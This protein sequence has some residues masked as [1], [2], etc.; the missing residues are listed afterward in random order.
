M[1]EV[2]WE[3]MFPDELEA[4]MAA[5]PVVWV[6]QG[7]CE[8]HGPQNALGLDALKA[9]AICVAAAREHGGIVA[10]VDFWHIH[11]TGLYA[12]WAFNAIG[13]MRTWMTA[14]PAWIHF[15]HVC[16]QWRAFDALG[17]HAAITVTGHYGANWT[18][19]K[20]LTGLVQ[21]HLAMRL[22]GLPDWEANINGFDGQGNNKGDHAG[23]VETSLLWALRPECV[24]VSRIPP[25]DV[26]KSLREER[27]HF[28]MGADAPL[29]D[30]RVGE[31]MVRD[32][33]AYLGRRAKELLAAYDRE[34]PKEHKP[35]SFVELERIWQ[36]VVKPKLPTFRTIQ[37]VEPQQVPPASSQWT[38]NCH[39][40]D[41]IG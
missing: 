9:Q 24:D 26:Q 1:R 10:P 23:K 17:F 31:R 20:T 37:N 35:V 33:V 12:P 28:A 29:A 16:Y 36:E 15:K 11:E 27:K 2:Q 5:C 19:L 14:V 41:G 18:D 8:P 13:E 22:Y 39:I 40:P 6:P 32:E 4:A 25:A 21:P 7:L 3:R 38:F 30:R 34:A